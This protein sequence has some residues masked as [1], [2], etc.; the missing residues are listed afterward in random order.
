MTGPDHQEFL[1]ALREGRT[2]ERHVG[3][4][5]AAAGLAVT[6]SEP[7][8]AET[9]YEGWKFR[10]ETDLLVGGDIIEVKGTSKQFTSRLDWP[11]P[12]AYVCAEKRWLE[13]PTKP[14]AFVFCSTVTGALVALPASTCGE[15][16]VAETRDGRRGYSYPVLRAPR[17]LLRPF[18]ALVGALA[19]RR[20]LMDD[21]KFLALVDEAIARRA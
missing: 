15:W 3:G 13:R 17:K 20:Q 14:Y 2:T 12:D 10:D 11:F 8:D 9:P 18:D 1:R 7:V 19:K 5:L 16:F 4:L 6:Y 21:D